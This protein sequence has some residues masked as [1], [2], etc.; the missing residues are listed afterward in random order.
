VDFFDI[1]ADVG[2]ILRIAGHES[3]ASFVPGQH[4]A[5]HPGQCAEICLRQERVGW[6][7]MLHPALEKALGF[8]QPVFLFELD[9]TPL[10]QREIVRFN[11]L[12][13]FP[14]VRRDIA[15]IVHE[16]VQ[17]A[18]LVHCVKQQDVLIRD[19]VMFDVYQGPGIAY[20]M[21]SVALGLVLQDDNE[22]LTDVR[23][24]AVIANALVHLKNQ[25][26]AQ[27]RE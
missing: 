10:L 25:F 4:H 15:L 26:D 9:Q 27:L 7:G 19:V 24:D 6:I 23:V 3:E 12:S 2:A 1:K 5:L 17:S 18:A 13:R 21:K 8:E 11:T 22:T 16:S 14:Q 20:A